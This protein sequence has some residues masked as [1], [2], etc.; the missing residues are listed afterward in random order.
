MSN[1]I[2]VIG[3]QLRAPQTLGRLGLAL[4]LDATNKEHLKTIKEYASSVLMEVEKSMSDPK[5]DLSRCAPE[6]LIQCMIDSAKFKIKIDGRQHAHIVKFGNNATLQIGFRGF[7]AK[8]REVM[9]SSDINAFAVYDGDELTISSENGF[10][11][12]SHKRGNPFANEKDLNG[13]VGVLYYQKEGKEFQRVLAMSKDE[14]T[15]IRGVAKQDFIWSKWFVEKAKVAVIKRLCKVT[16]AE[17]SSIQEL[18]DFDNKENFDMD[19]NKP[20]ID[21]TAQLDEF[22][23]KALDEKSND[24][25]IEHS[26]INTD[27]ETT[28]MDDSVS[29]TP[30]NDTQEGLSVAGDTQ[31]V[32]EKPV[33]ETCKGKGCVK[34]N[35]GQDNETISPCDACKPQPK[36]DL[37]GDS[38]E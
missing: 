10:D 14:V 38:H 7:I 16:F 36:T 13:V 37:L 24:E 26:E 15:K 6:S 29:K 25:V 17:I 23:Q 33:C 5:K 1:N 35:E 32:V 27:D 22:T 12:Y 9:P 20:K 19:A 11:T 18:V 28:G 3:Q 21:E 8:I 2:E 34:Q 4:G 31:T 30:E